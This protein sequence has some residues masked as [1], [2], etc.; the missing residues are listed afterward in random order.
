MFVH[1][2]K[3][4]GEEFDEEP[5]LCPGHLQGALP[6]L[7]KL[8]GS[9][10]VLLLKPLKFRDFIVYSFCGNCHYISLLQISNNSFFCCLFFVF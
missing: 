1:L 8:D 4:K 3:E 9:I 2:K 5:S 10:E 7:T 6:L